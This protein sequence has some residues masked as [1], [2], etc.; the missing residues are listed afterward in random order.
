MHPY[1]S[2]HETAEGLYRLSRPGFSKKRISLPSF[3]IW[4][5][6]MPPT[7]HPTSNGFLQWWDDMGYKKTHIPFGMIVDVRPHDHPQVEGTWLW[8]GDRAFCDWDMDGAIRCCFVRREGRA[9]Q[10]VQPCL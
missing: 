5:L 6:N 1:A 9:V 3:S 7:K 8:Q 10:S 4:S 2:A